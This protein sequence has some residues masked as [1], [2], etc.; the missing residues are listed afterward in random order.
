MVTF[1]SLLLFRKGSNGQ[2]QVLLSKLHYN[3][4]E[5]CSESNEE[6]SWECHIY[7]MPDPN[8]TSAL[9]R[10]QISEPWE[11]SETPSPASPSWSMLSRETG[12]Q[13][14]L[15]PWTSSKTAEVTGWGKATGFSQS[16][17]GW[18]VWGQTFIFRGLPKWPLSALKIDSIHQALKICINTDEHSLSHGK[19][20]QAAP[21]DKLSQSPRYLLS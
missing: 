19:H 16:V 10:P 15:K 17:C 9:R 8:T 2:A 18:E 20:Q 14:V 1:T 11:I 12:I 5:F 7:S 4:G 13:E 3:L 6:L 21:S